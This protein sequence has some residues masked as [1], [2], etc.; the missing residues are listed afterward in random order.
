MQELI[1]ILNEMAE[2][3]GISEDDMATIQEAISNVE[4]SGDEEFEYKEDVDV[5]KDSEK[6]EDCED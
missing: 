1:N 4:S 3:Y 5:S 2:K 6:P